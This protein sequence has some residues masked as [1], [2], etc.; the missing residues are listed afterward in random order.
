M[1]AILVKANSRRVLR[2]NHGKYKIRKK[3]SDFLF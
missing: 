1:P 3:R 2:L